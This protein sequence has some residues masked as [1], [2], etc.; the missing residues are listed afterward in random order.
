MTTK[1]LVRQG[2]GAA[3]EIDYATAFTGRKGTPFFQENTPLLQM[4]Q[5]FQN[6]ECAQGFFKVVDPDAELSSVGF[7]LRPW[8]EV[9][10]TEDASGDELIIAWNRL[11]SGDVA[12]RG[13]YVAGDE[14]EHNPTLMDCNL[15]VRGIPFAPGWVR[16]AETDWDRLEALQLAKLNGSSSTSPLFR[17]TT[18]ITV[19]RVSNG[20]L[21]KAD[22][23]TDLE[24]KK[25]PKGTDVAEIIEDI[26][27]Q[28]G[29]LWGIVLHHDGGSTHKCLLYI[30]QDDLETWTTG[31]R[32]SDDPADWDPDD[33]AT[34]TFEPHWLQGSGKEADYSSVISGLISIYDGPDDN[35]QV[36]TVETGEAPSDWETFW[37]VYNDGE[38]ANDTQAERRANW[39]LQDRKRPYISHRVSV[40]VTAAQAHLATAGQAIE[41]KSVVLNSGADKNNFVWRRI[42]ESKLE[43]AADGLYWLHLSL[44]RPR[45]SR[46]AGGGPAQPESTA[47]R[48]ARPGIIETSTAW[49][50]F[51]HASLASGDIN[52]EPALWKE[53]GYDDSVSPW[54]NA[55]L[56]GI[57]P[58]TDT[59]EI[60]HPNADDF[61][62]R[63]EFFLRKQYYIDADELVGS[64]VN[65]HLYADDGATVYVNG[66]SVH[67]V[68]TPFVATGPH[69]VSTTIP[70]ASFQEGL[71][72]VGIYL[73][74]QDSGTDG[75][76]PPGGCLVGLKIDIAA[77]HVDLGDGDTGEVLPADTAIHASEVPI[78]DVGNHYDSGNVEGALQEAAEL[79]AEL[80]EA[81]AATVDELLQGKTFLIA[82][83]RGDNNP[84][85]GYPEDSLEAVLQ[86]AQRGADLISFNV[87][88]SSD[89]TFWGSHDLTLDRTTTGTGAIS[90]T[91]D[92]TLAG[93]NYDAGLGYDAGRHGSSIG[94]TTLEEVLTG[95]SQYGGVLALEYKGGDIAELAQQVVDAGWASR[96]IIDSSTGVGATDLANAAIVKGISTQIRMQV[97]Q[98]VSGADTDDNVDWLSYDIDSMSSLADT[99]TLAPKPVA[100]Y[101]STDDWGLDET[102]NFTN[103]FEW[104]ARTWASL[105]LTDTLRLRN[106]A[107]FGAPGP[108]DTGR[109]E[110][111]TNGDIA[112]PEIVF[113]TGDVVMAW[114]ED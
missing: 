46:R 68:G 25:Y 30:D 89:G 64:D 1:L 63:H 47:T 23:E 61:L 62:K 103:A 9:K 50:V 72:C 99:R 7:R 106:T 53:V 109:W 15:D 27:E 29:K 44:E 16:P 110:P 105:N 92:A 11:A 18:D 57:D 42:A 22:P 19:D 76:S 114:V 100:A 52:P 45:R 54:V 88:Q 8:A 55:G 58:D 32:I 77:S 91:T 66:T 70:R 87:V 34:P 67:S 39:I 78:S 93:L 107:E 51:E 75:L 41:V 71:N 108:T 31:V 82:A 101:G 48:P 35:R 74:N 37:A 59:T 21:V 56:A 4:G 17:E 5:R 95:L 13:L 80:A 49:R 81:A 98:A 36:V 111:V 65:L 10:L 113:D 102:S 33:P 28:S 85:D 84:D 2:G 14:I 112:T 90:G 97:N 96:T 79:A 38:S 26:A 6:G 86:A 40:L 94:L 3:A 20:H 83:R 69:N 73:W 24:A 43:P 60:E 12:R 104:G